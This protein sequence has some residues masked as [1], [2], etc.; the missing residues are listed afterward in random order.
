LH[1]LRQCG[2]LA[3]TFAKRCVKDGAPSFRGLGGWATLPR[4]FNVAGNN[5]TGNQ[6]GSP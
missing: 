5:A 6:A 1:L 2:E 4:K 3:E